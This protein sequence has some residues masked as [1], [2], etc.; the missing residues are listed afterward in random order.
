[1]RHHENCGP[2]RLIGLDEVAA[3]KVHSFYEGVLCSL[4]FIYPL[5]NLQLKAK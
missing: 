5:D 1:M 2:R 3:E 4:V